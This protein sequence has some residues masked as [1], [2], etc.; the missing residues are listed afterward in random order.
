MTGAS[1]RGASMSAKLLYSSFLILTGIGYIAALAF[2]YMTHAGLDGKPG[3]NM[4]DIVESYYGNRTGTRLEAAIRG[5]MKSHIKRPE[6]DIVAAWLSSGAS[7]K[8]YEARVKPILQQDCMT[9]HNPASSATLKIPDLSTF[10]GLQ[11]VTKVDKGASILSLVGLS[12][13]HLFGISLVLFAVGVIFI[14]AELTSWLK[15][16]LIVLPFVAILADIVAWFMTRLYPLY[17]YVVVI[18]GALM[19]LAMG[20]QILISLYQ[21]WLVS[22]EPAG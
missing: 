21:M 18:G 3:V 12:H 9:C 8:D 2:L 16:P 7:E 4:A 15:Y 20:A 6:R 17:A 14:R 22:P 13:V 5:P 1:L 10:S 11:Q 19:G